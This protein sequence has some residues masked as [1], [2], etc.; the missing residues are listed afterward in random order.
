MVHSMFVICG[1]LNK[2]SFLIFH[3][4][5][6]NTIFTLKK[7]CLYKLHL[8]SPI[9]CGISP[10]PPSSPAPPVSL[11][12]S[13]K[14]LPSPHLLPLP[15]ETFL[16]VL[17]LQPLPNNFLHG[18]PPQSPTDPMD[19]GPLIQPW[20]TPSRPAYFHLAL[21]PTNSRAPVPLHWFHLG[22]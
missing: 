22:Q 17:E 9:L 10:S 21:C 14:H 7:G 15:G 11:S 3:L 2:C 18:A 6:I 12:P 13:I 1:T 16:E 20:G 5:F 8:Q 4:L 19:P